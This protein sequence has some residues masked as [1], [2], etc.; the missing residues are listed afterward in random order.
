MSNVTLHL[1]IALRMALACGE[2]I[3]IDALAAELER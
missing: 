1:T 3:I 2:R